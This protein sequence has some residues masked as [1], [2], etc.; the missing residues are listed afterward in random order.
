MNA[1]PSEI[2]PVMAEVITAVSGFYEYPSEARRVLE[3][4]L[5]FLAQRCKND[6]ELIVQL[7]LFKANER[8]LYKTRLK[9]NVRRHVRL[10]Q[11][12]LDYSP[13]CRIGHSLGAPAWEAEQ[14]YRGQF[15]WEA[16]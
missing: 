7:E 1:S 4:R 15:A 13:V 2:S 3:E 16:N 8:K 5:K 12:A 14:Y 6:S 11:F 9:H 10:L